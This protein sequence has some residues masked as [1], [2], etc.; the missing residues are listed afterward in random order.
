MYISRYY[1][2]HVQEVENLT[3]ATSLKKVTMHYLTS[4]SRSATSFLRDKVEHPPSSPSTDTGSSPTTTIPVKS[5]RLGVL[6]L[7]DYIRMYVHYICL[8][9]EKV[10]YSELTYCYLLNCYFNLIHPVAPVEYP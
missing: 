6:V 2:Y 4:A 10:M 9:L 5:T 3:K 8:C 1:M 7:M